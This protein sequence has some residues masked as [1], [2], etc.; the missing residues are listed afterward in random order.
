M[1]D[2]AVSVLVIIGLVLARAFGWLWL[3]P[4]AAF[5]GAVV[6]ANWAVRRDGSER[7]GV[8][9]YE[10]SAPRILIVIRP[11]PADTPRRMIKAL[12]LIFEPEP[13]WE[14]VFVAHRSLLNI[15]FTFLLPM[16]ALS[17]AVEAS[18]WPSL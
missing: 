12:L 14:R 10:S 17:A 18:G 5:I 6:T 13:A 8:A 15:L 7:W 9:W 1:A 2:A 11:R 3:D 16:I 4:V